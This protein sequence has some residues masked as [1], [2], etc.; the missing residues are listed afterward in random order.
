MLRNSANALAVFLL[1]TSAI[2]SAQVAGRLSGTVVDPSGAPIPNATVSLILGGGTNAVVKSTSNG[3]GS[4]LFPSIR[5]EVYDVVFEANG[6]RKNAVR[7]VK[8]PTLRP[9]S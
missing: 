3:E 2:V 7:G 9:R 5:P 6:F 1:A 4:F 8:T